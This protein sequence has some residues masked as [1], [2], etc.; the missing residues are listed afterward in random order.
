MLKGL[1]YANNPKTL[2][3]LKANITSEINKIDKE[4]LEKVA[5]NIV[6]RAKKC[7]EAGGGHFGNNL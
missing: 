6:H 3:E 7:I 5:F 4:L 2:V 1:V